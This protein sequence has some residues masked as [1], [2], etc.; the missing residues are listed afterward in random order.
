M[1]RG[2]MLM[3]L[4]V[5]VALIGVLLAATGAILHDLTVEPPRAFRATRAHR[6]LGDMLLQLQKDLRTAMDVRVPDRDDESTKTLLIR[7]AGGT[8]R[9]QAGPDGVF[10]DRRE[11]GGEFRRLGAWPE[12]KARVEWAVRKQGG[13]PVA[14]E[15]RT[16]VMMLQNSRLVRRFVNARM[17]FLG[18]Q[19]GAGPA[20]GG[21]PRTQPATPAGQ[22]GRS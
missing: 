12:P 11:P 22:G 15:V 13:R 7:Q 19:D 16:G 5:T 3:E 17:F 21:R 4:V 6:M 18:R 14:V 10:R 1:R 9:Y 8:V 20:A 2:V